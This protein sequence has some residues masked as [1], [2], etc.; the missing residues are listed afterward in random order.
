MTIF[1]ILCVQIGCRDDV[2]GAFC[3]AHS[4]RRAAEKALAAILKADIGLEFWIEEHE[5]RL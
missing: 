4:T 3:T 5:V 1:V 2:A